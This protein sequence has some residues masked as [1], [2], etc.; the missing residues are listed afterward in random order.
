MAIFRLVAEGVTDWDI[1]NAVAPLIADDLQIERLHPEEVSD[2]TNRPLDEPGWVGVLRYI[3]SE[4]FA[5]VV[6]DLADDEYVVIQID[7]DI[8]QEPFFAV[9]LST[10]DGVSLTT[11][12]IVERVSEN[13]R[14]RC[15]KVNPSLLESRVILAVCVDCS[16]CWLLPYFFSAPASKK[17]SGCIRKL[18]EVLTPKHKLPG[19]DQN[20]KQHAIY[21]AIAH[22]ARKKRRRDFTVGN[23]SLEIFISVARAKLSGAC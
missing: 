8:A 3:A 17:V 21:Q 7:S 6:E 10:P 9:D 1:L 19:I 2:N 23:A 14:G 20:N 11:Q 4:K 16:E 13:L 15:D 18:N 5:Q 12:L 22:Y